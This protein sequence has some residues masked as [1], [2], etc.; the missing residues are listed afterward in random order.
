MWEAKKN[1]TLRETQSL[2][3][4]RVGGS[5]NETLTFAF[6]GFLVAPRVGRSNNETLTFLSIFAARVGELPCP[7]VLSGLMKP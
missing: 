6:P 4:A 3:A 2:A 7:L 5:N 1:I